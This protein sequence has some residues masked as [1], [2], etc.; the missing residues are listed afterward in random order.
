MSEES[1]T[2]CYRCNHC[3]LSL[4]LRLPRPG[5]VA[6]SWL[7]AACENRFYATL[8]DSYPP[9]ILSH[10]RPAADVNPR[11]SIGG[12]TLATMYKRQGQLGRVF[13]G[14]GSARESSDAVLSVS[15]EE[16]EVE[17]HAVDLSAGGIGFISPRPLEPGSLVVV[18]FETLPGKPVTTCVVRNCTAIEGGGHRIG[19]AFKNTPLE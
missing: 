13:E 8:V 7:C 9:E 15:T 10:V 2:N 4:P 3:G 16:E 18:Q 11:V 1:S 6:S 14:R 19:A 5:E 17:A 12:E